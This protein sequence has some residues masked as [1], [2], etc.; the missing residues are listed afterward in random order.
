[1]KS[2]YKYELAEAASKGSRMD[3]PAIRHRLPS[4]GVKR[5]VYEK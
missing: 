2:A 4:S 1:M 3:L 5:I